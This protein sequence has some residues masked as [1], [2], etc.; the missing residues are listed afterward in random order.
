MI[1]GRI[2]VQEEVRAWECS[3]IED[4]PMTAKRETISRRHPPSLF[5][6]AGNQE[7]ILLVRQILHFHS[8][9]KLVQ[10]DTFCETSY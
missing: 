5:V 2:Q 8:S 7:A 3:S 9:G 1:R 4:S 10:D 6:P